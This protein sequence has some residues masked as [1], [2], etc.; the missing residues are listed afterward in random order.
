MRLTRTSEMPVSI[1][2]ITAPFLLRLLQLQYLN[3]HPHLFLAA[4]LSVGNMSLS[5]SRVLNFIPLE[6][7]FE[8]FPTLI[9]SPASPLY[10]VTASRYLPTS[11]LME[12]VEYSAEY[13]RPEV[14]RIYSHMILAM[15][16]VP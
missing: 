10:P 14:R 3:H 9:A 1:V 15:C 13:H 5:L 2:Q 16:I 4:Q 12:N 8:C 6:T 7:K 11:S